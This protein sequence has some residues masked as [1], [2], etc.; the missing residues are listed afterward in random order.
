M[1]LDEHQ[2]ASTPTAVSDDSDLES[3]EEAN[4]FLPMSPGVVRAVLGC[5]AVYTVGVCSMALYHTIEGGVSMAGVALSS[6]WL[7]FW[8]FFPFI[9]Y[10][11]SYGWCHPL[12][13][14]SLLRIIYMVP[15]STGVFMSGLPEHLMLPDWSSTELNWLFAYGNLVNS[16]A[17]IALYI[18]FAIGPRLPVPSLRLAYIPPPL[19]LY[20]VLFIFFG[21]SLVAF[22]LY[23]QISGGFYNHVKNL[24]FGMAKKIDLAGE[25][26]GIGQ[27][28]TLM[29][30]ATVAAVVWVCAQPRAF[31]NPAFC[32]FALFALVMAYLS[33]GKRS[34]MIYPAILI[35]LCWMLRNQKVPYASLALVGVTAFFLLGLLGLFRSSNWSPAETLDLTFLSETSIS[36]VSRGSLEELARRSGSD[37]T[38]F[39]ILAKVPHE[40]GLLY[41]RSYLEW[42]LRFIPRELWPDKPRGVDVQANLT[43]Y[44][45]DWGMPAGAVGEAYWNFHLPGVLMVF[46][47]LGCFK[48]WMRD[49]LLRY[50]EAPAVMIICM[51]SLFYFDASQNGFRIWVY[52]IVPALIILRLGGLWGGKPPATESLSAPLP[53]H[54]HAS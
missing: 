35:M 7:I 8:T 34:H 30:M 23:A 39:P 48:R 20:L 52:S 21:I 17:L 31:R 53:A 5:G 6:A 14:V 46:F 4:P 40:E 25:V 51:I 10:K 2:S 22:L 37:S 43:F 44:G 42:G 38:Y 11:R 28:T 45:A 50:P 13:L 26:D 3:A 18:G 19:R 32:L 24:A 27:Y 36:E 41:G 16:L 29:S 1:T 47:L 12:I 49:L 54:S 15:K 9:F 33:E